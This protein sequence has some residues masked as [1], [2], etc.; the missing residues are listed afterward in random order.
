MGTTS[1]FP[2]DFQF[3]C[4]CAVKGSIISL[5]K[6]TFNSSSRQSKISLI[7]SSDIPTSPPKTNNLSLI[8]AKSVSSKSP[9]SIKSQRSSNELI[10]PSLSSSN[11]CIKSSN[12]SSSVITFVKQSSHVGSSSSTILLLL[13]IHAN[14]ES[15]S[16]PDGLPSSFPKELAPT[17]PSS[18]ACAS[19]VAKAPRACWNAPIVYVSIEIYIDIVT[20]DFKH[21]YYLW[22]CSS[23]CF[24]SI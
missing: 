7:L 15:L 18:A 3:I 1:H 20:F 21:Y 5:G 24:F 12:F 10:T 2:K 9:E 16:E 17:S 13:Y 8:N 4:C 11:A 6:S 19:S 23:C 22:I 14:L